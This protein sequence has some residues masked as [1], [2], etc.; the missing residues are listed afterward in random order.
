MTFINIYKQVQAAN[1]FG[2]SEDEYI[3]ELKSLRELEDVKIWKDDFVN[4]CIIMER[5]SIGTI[6]D[7]HDV[8]FF[9]ERFLDW[10][11]RVFYEDNE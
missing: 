1:A 6:T 4:W 11:N 9:K 2:A 5:C 8:V 10:M 3:D 7:E